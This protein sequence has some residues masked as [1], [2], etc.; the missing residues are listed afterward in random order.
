MD[1]KILIRVEQLYR[2]YGHHLAVE[3]INFQLSQG[4]VLGFLGPNG[5][6]KSTT[7][8]MITG[9]LAPSAGRVC[10]NDI[11]LLDNPKRAKAEIGYLPEQPPVYRDLTVNEYLHYCAR[12]HRV[13]RN[14]RGA[15]VSRAKKRCG[16]AGVGRRLIGN[17]SKGYQQRVGIAQAILHNPAVVVLD[18]PTAGLDPNQIRDIRT[19]IRELGETHG[20]ILS[21]HILPEVQ[22]TCSNVQI[23]H[24][25]RLVFSERMDEL[26]RRLAGHALILET[27]HPLDTNT[28]QQL[29]EVQSVTALAR[30]RARLHFDNDNPAATVAACVAS[31]G[32]GLVELALDR[33]TLEQVFVDLTCS[34]V[35][36][37]QTDLA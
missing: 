36:Q 25:G 9:N 30:N 16:L 4:E 14:Q 28:L 5:A 24:Q 17:L 3:G 6:G 15:C 31:Q 11:D 1:A 29:A 37:Q 10:I 26:E 19:L 35:P 33:Q 2:Y 13:S 7:M 23:I 27:G 8:Q 20:I 21:T 12:L 34:D 22:A 32:W 18:E